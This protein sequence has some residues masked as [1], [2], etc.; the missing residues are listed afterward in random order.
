MTKQENYSQRVADLI[1]QAFHCLGDGLAREPGDG[2]ED[3]LEEAQLRMAAAQAIASLA[4]ARESRVR[5]L[6][7][8][9]ALESVGGDAPEP[10]IARE[11]YAQAALMLGM[12]EDLDEMTMEQL[13]DLL[14]GDKDP[15]DADLG[16]LS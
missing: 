14:T 7:Q 4:T 10:L 3:F 16:D 2:R 9:A 12:V 5:A 11:A 6:L 1:E 8:L 15:A 13:R